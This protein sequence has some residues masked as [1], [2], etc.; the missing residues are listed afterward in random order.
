MQNNKRLSTYKRN[1]KQTMLEESELEKLGGSSLKWRNTRIT[2]W[3]W[4]K[5]GKRWWAKKNERD[6]AKWEIAKDWIEIFER[7]ERNFK[8]SI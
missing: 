5:E 1:N 6:S 2:M 8:N 3:E 7:T 4:F